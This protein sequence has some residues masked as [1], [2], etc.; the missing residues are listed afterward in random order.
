MGIHTLVSPRNITILTEYAEQVPKGLFIEVGVYRGGSAY[1]LSKIA[2]KKGNDIWLFDTFE[3]MPESTPELDK[4]KVGVFADCS[5]EEVK[6]LIPYAKIFK[7]FFPETLPMDIPKVSFVHVD[8][9]Q[10]E[11]VKACILLLIPYMVSGGIM[12]FDDYSSLEGAIKA[13]DEFCPERI[14]LDNK[15][16]IFIKG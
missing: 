8:C 12:Y 15:K 1:Y 2:E 9:D 3:G 6:K 7:G 4:H 10:Y 13:V 14:V 5:Y 16:A 11:S